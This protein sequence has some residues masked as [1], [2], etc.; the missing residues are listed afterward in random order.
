VAARATVKAAASKNSMQR[1]D[2]SVDDRDATTKSS[3]SASRVNGTAN[4]VT[5]AGSGSSESSA[6][7][8]TPSVPSLP[9]NQSTGSCTGR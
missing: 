7:R 6:S 8:M 1:G 4:P 5:L 2:T 3:A 9:I